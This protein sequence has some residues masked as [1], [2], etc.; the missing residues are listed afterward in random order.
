MRTACIF[1]ALS[2]ENSVAICQG[3]PKSYTGKRY[4]KLAPPWWMVKSVK[5][6]AQF[7]AKYREAILSKLDAKQVYDELVALAGPDPILLCW[8]GFNMRCHRRLVAEWL[9]QALGIEIPE[10]GH[11]RAESLPFV[12]MPSAPPKIKTSNQLSFEFAGVK[13]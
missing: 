9:E 1:K 8:E 5:D 12:Q 13:P 4:L 2:F 10:V 3:V 6:P 7:E 11:E